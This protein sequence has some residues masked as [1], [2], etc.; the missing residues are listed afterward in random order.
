MYRA[1]S[2]SGVATTWSHPLIVRYGN[3]VAGSAIIEEH[4]AVVLACCYM[5]RARGVSHLPVSPARQ[6]RTR[7]REMSHQHEETRRLLA[8][9]TRDD[10]VHPN[11]FLEYSC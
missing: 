11:E 9:D 10:D 8:V 7:R 1:N 5:V 6:S 4:R 2:Q 3:R